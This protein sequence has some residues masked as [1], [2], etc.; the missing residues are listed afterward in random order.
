VTD[1]K[2]LDNVACTR[3]GKVLATALTEGTIKLLDSASGRELATLETFDP[4]LFA[5]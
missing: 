3:D 4:V 1:G 5:R 2:S